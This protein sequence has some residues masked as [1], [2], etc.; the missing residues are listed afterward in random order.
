MKLSINPNQ[1]KPLGKYILVKPLKEDSVTASGIHLPKE[2]RP[3]I[4]EV[5]EVGDPSPELSGIK[6]GVKILHKKWEG[7]DLSL[8]AGE[9]MFLS[10]EDV[11]AVLG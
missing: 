8:E 5:I 9:F 2:E 11:I 6:P 4:S 10:H 3:N 1:I 7:T